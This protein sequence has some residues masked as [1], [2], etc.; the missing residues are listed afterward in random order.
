[1]FYVFK[2]NFGLHLASIAFFFLSMVKNGVLC[3]NKKNYK[4]EQIGAKD[5]VIFAISCCSWFFCF[6][7]WLQSSNFVQWY[8]DTNN[9]NNEH[10]NWQT[11]ESVCANVIISVS[12][13]FNSTFFSTWE[14]FIKLI[15]L[16]QKA[17]GCPQCNLKTINEV[18]KIHMHIQF[19]WNC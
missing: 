12:T 9:V 7:M 10:G 5:D 6:A 1:M 15:S 2:L 13:L 4:Y 19:G 17:L 3:L 8:I 14:I 11:N 16:R 18:A